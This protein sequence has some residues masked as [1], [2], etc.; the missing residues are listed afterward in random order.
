MLVKFLLFVQPLSSSYFLRRFQPPFSRSS[1][2]KFL[3]GTVTKGIKKYMD[4]RYE[5][6]E[7]GMLG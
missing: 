2:E 1:P 7:N 3:L 5:L 6:P 4:M